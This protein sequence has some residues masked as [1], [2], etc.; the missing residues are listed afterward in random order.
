MQG[1]SFSYSEV[2]GFGWS[3][4]K[5]NFW[6]FVGVW[7]V[8][9]FVSFFVSLPG[10]ILREVMKRYP[11]AIPQAIPPFWF[12][13]VLAV[14]FIIE[15]IL[16]IGLIKITLS[17][18]D[19]QKPRFGT[20]F[21]GLDCFWRYLG[22]RLLYILIIGGASVACILPFVLLS[23]VMRKLHLALP[24]SVV[25]VILLV[26]LSIKFSLCL[27][28]VVDKGLGPINA[29]RASSRATRGAIGSLFVFSI[30]CG[31]II[32][33][34]MLCF[35][36]G[37]FA[38][39]PM[40]MLAMAFVYRQ[41]SEQTPELA[42]LGIK[43]PSFKPQAGAQSIGGMQFATVIQSVVNARPDQNV[44]SRETVRPI[45][46]TQ[47]ATGMRSDPVVQSGAGI[48]L[49]QGVQLSPGVQP[50]QGVKSSPEAQPS[51]GILPAS[52]IQQRGEEKKRNKP[53]LYWLT[54]LIILSV[55]LVVGIG[56]RLWPGLKGK[57]AVSSK[58]VVISPQEVVTTPKEVSLKGILYSE[59]NPSAII[60]GK[61]AKEGDIINDINVI[62]IH[63]DRV[64]FEKDGVK[65]T[66]RAR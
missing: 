27:Y 7:V 48:Q 41:L 12:F 5:S 31:L 4:M 32:I 14:T 56:Y 60:D 36:V 54:A 33:L 10:Q 40:I 17:F 18:C 6:F 26:T 42:D 61:I 57:V 63:K 1:K 37:L 46:G 45:S 19:G 13:V 47:T 23:G 25:I 24:A 35:L 29:L 9:F 65:W 2:L 44:Q 16:E 8:S 62:K 50:N 49:G 22:G 34:G 64:E 28:F 3:V 53:F 30:L 39:I 58:E 52:G 20:L 15:I 38:T 21:N 51:K 43:G 55:V 11:G 59:D 66:Q